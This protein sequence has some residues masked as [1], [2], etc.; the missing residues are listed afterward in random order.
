MK[1]LRDHLDGLSQLPEYLIPWLPENFVAIYSPRLELTL[2]KLFCR[3][4]ILPLVEM[5]QAKHGWATSQTF[6][7]WASKQWWRQCLPQLYEF[8]N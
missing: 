6:D 4:S 3:P 8:L 5:I 2:W 7:D 1:R